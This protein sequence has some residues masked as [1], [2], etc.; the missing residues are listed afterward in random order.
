MD[1]GDKAY[2]H[3][4]HLSV[5]PLRIAA[6]VAPC[7]ALAIKTPWIACAER[8]KCNYYTQVLFGEII[9]LRDYTKTTSTVMRR[10]FD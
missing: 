4:R 6:V 3:R 10:L 1:R 9:S 7:W 2:L 8:Q 5:A